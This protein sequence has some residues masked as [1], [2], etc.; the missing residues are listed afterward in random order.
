ML[1]AQR[2][3]L[4]EESLNPQRSRFT[5]EPLEPGFGYTLGNSL[6]RTL[7]S[8]IPGAAVTSVRISGVPHEFTTLPGVEED[9]TEILLNIK[10]IV[11]TSE[12]DEPVV[13]Y[14]RKSGKGEAT[15]GDITPPAGVTIANPDMHIATLAEDG[16]L[17]IEFTVER[18]RG[19]V[20]AQMNKQD[21]AEIGR[22]DCIH[23]RIV[24]KLQKGRELRHLVIARQ[25][26]ARHVHG[27]ALRV[28]ELHGG[29]DT[30]RCEIFGT[31][32]HTKLRAGQIYCVRA[33]MERHLQ[34][35]QISGGA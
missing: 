18:G 16:E 33:E 23:T 10:G 5:I 8:S 13:M 32:A 2:P 6:R 24:E 3:T 34:A 20:P 9:V 12:Y 11:L 28:R 7:L 4:T 31:G 25:G 21:N 17:E 30:V 35:L 14:L 15:A 26:V 1:I 27:R 22:D 19:Y 29:A